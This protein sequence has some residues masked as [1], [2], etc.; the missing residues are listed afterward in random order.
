[1]NGRIRAQ[2][3]VFRCHEP[4]PLL[5][6]VIDQ[7]AM[8]WQRCLP[9]CDTLIDK[10]RVAGECWLVFHDNEQTV[11]QQELDRGTVVGKSAR[12]RL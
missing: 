11:V 6:N 1:M 3:F 8:K 12:Y 7:P 5:A 4:A 2:C 10:S 9:V